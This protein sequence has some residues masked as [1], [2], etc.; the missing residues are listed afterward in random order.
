MF[1]DKN[2][3]GKLPVVF[4][5]MLGLVLFAFGVLMVL[6]SGFWSA[7][8]LQFLILFISVG[9]IY[10]TTGLPP[11]IEGV[12]TMTKGGI[13]LFRKETKKP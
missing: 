6:F 8:S 5:A 10:I 2:T 7:G 1:F 12:M 9:V 11:M 3:F 4:Q 13:T